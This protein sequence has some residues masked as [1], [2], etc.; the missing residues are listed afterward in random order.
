MSATYTNGHG[1][2]TNGHGHVDGHGRPVDLDPRVAAVVDR[3]PI[4]RADV[5][6]MQ[7]RASELDRKARSFVRDNPTTTVVAAV[8]VGFL[9][10]RL[11]TR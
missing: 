5:A 11:V 3:L 4:D 1:H 9:I 7:Q 8:A 6:Q 10:G 2:V